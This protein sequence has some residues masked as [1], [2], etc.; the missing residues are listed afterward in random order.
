MKLTLR[1]LESN[2]EIQTSILRSLLPEVKK[3]L[4]GAINK[5]KI[6]LPL[7][8]EQSILTTPEYMSLSS[9]KLRLE[10]GIPDP[11]AKINGLINIWLNNIEYIY[12]TPSIQGQTIR[13][14]FSAGLVKTDYSDV[15]GSNFAQVIDQSGYSLPWL[16]WLLLDGNKIIV[17]SHQV[18]IGPN[19]A[20]RT[21]F[22]IMRQS[23]VGWQ[24]PTEFA[25]TAN[26]N[27]ITR[28][29]DSA[30]PEIEQ[31]LDRVLL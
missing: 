21:G 8:L 10:F 22:A 13:A 25:G 11:V 24:V 7:L 15:L 16:Q 28:A 19:R 2:Q 1:I 29:I 18:V 20:S 9:G 30:A 27:W 3:Y 4:D 14:N 23:S 31:L 6:S 17:P 12:Q 26:D 5:L